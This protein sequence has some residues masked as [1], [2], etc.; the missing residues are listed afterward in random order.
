MNWNRKVELMRYGIVGVP[1]ALVTCMCILYP[2]YRF[3][4]G[5]AIST[6]FILIAAFFYGWFI[7]E[8]RMFWNWLYVHEDIDIEAA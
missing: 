7:I 4:N 1:V 3:L 2:F 6:D 8:E 5:A